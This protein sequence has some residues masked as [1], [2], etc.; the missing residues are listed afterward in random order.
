MQKKNKESKLRDHLEDWICRPFLNTKNWIRFRTWD[1]QHVLKIKTLKPGWMDKDEV[2]IHAMFQILCNFIEQEKPAECIDW[3]ADPKNAK[4]WKEVQFLY[5]WWKNNRLKRKDPFDDP[6][7]KAPE[8]K[9]I[10]RKK[11]DTNEE[12]L[13]GIEWVYENPEHEKLWKK[14]CEEHRQW[15]EHCHAEDNEMMKRLI[16]IRDFLWT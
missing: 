1:K 5:D 10:P 12:T 8:W 13:Y 7:F 11:K 9:F 2:L 4:A 16:D 6:S 3:D 15:E 14:K